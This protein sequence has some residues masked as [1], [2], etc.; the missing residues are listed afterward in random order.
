LL[1][2]FAAGT[3]L[4]WRGSR[5]SRP[6]GVALLLYVL[7]QASWLVVLGILIANRLEQP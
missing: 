6:M 3:A 1:M 2:V 5:A 4:Y 7:S